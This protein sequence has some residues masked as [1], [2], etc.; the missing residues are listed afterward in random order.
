MRF[1]VVFMVFFGALYAQGNVFS[2]IPVAKIEI[3]NLNPEPCS[4]SCLKDLAEEKKIFSFIARF[5]REIEDEELQNIML[6]FTKQLGI[7]Y[8]IRFDT[9]QDKLNI[10]LL[11][12]KKTIGKYST[13]TIDTIL[14]YLAFRDIDFKF[15]VFDS[16]DENAESIENA[17]NAMQNEH[18]N[19]A[20]A[21]LSKEENLP[22]LRRVKIPIYIPTL[23][24]PQNF[25][26]AMEQIT[27]GGIDYDAQIAMLLD[28]SSGKNIISYNDDSALGAMIGGIVEAKS[29]DYKRY[30]EVVTNKDATNFSARLERQKNLLKE[31]S[32][33]LNTRVVISGLLLSQIGL[34]KETPPYI[35]STQ[36][37][38][39]PALLS[40]LRGINTKNLLIANSIG[41]SD[42]RLLEYSALLSG[43]LKYDWVNYSTALGVD[44][45]LSKMKDGIERFFKE[46]VENSQVAYKTQLYGI[47]NNGFVKY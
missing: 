26:N 34:L 25:D 2:N 33:F 1:L 37:N 5:S 47:E 42:E 20:I 17:L 31:S 45:F 16:V 29:E 43:D 32:V 38:Y 24:S 19:F 44:L 46:S 14:S 12:P 10:A 41:T 28:K 39:N 9:L 22:L 21:I 35:F 8:K 18:F 30:S 15:K 11:I 40:L 23:K 3:I 36:I 4:K 6:D 27:F 7:Y 13:T